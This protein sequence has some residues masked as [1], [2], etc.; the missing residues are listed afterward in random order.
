MSSAGTANPELA[1]QLRR[2]LAGATLETVPEGVLIWWGTSDL[3]SG[4]GTEPALNQLAWEG[5]YLRLQNGA[6]APGIV[7]PL[8][9]VLAGTTACRPDGQLPIAIARFSYAVPRPELAARVE[10]AA[11]EGRS[12]EDPPARI[13][14]QLHQRG[15]FFASCLLHDQWGF[16]LPAYRGRTV[17]FVVSEDFYLTNPGAAFP[18]TVAIDLGDGRGFL[19]VEFGQPIQATYAA[20]SDA[21]VAIRCTY[22]SETL[23]ASFTV[24]LS[25]QPAAPAPDES[26]P[27]E[28]DGGNT[29]T[30]FVY[31]ASGRAT[32]RRPVVI[33]EG[34]PGGHPADY[35]Y[36]ILEQQG[37]ATAL[38]AAGYD[39]VIVCLDHGTDEIQRNAQ[40]LVACIRE[41]R[42]RTDEPLIVGGVSM[43]GLVSRFA[44]AEMEARNEP[45]N[46]EVLLTIDTPH[47][48]AYTS[49][50]VQWFVHAFAPI[51]P[52]LAAQ[53]ELLNSPAN[54][55]FVLWCLRD[56]VPQTSPLRTAFLEE[57][58]GLGGY[59]K[60][61]RRLAISSGRGDG[62]STVPP[63]S[64]TLS[65][66]GQPWV[67]A[68]L[69]ALG[70]DGAETVGQGSWLLAEP[71]QLPALSFD[72]GQRPWEGAPGGQ[73]R[74][75]GQVA[76]IA[77]AVG[78]GTVTHAFDETCSVPTVSAL[79]LDQDP[80]T[81]VP[82]AGSGSS[83]FH[84]YAF[85]S[86]NQPHLTITAE[87][88]AWLLA[89]LGVT[90][91][92]GEAPAD[93]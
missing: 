20:P 44:L 50:A 93:G 53:A 75:N 89:A 36:D 76:A 49:L 85:C 65:W 10:Q 86:E 29:G 66:A 78:C 30:A 19:P 1:A 90:A 56:G 12:L 23:T 82:P 34:F 28:G 70:S 64:Q 15:A 6:L 83:P 22:G 24:P 5:E 9:T 61:P 77:A 87:V 46:A 2:L 72:S 63:G 67:S 8:D 27:L 74:Y 17:E 68:E 25:D 47:G 14:D 26:W 51:L 13:D 55:Q 60:Q 59:P 43:G 73:E 84:D 37:T 91:A 58:N 18:D 69:R 71:S 80:S 39:I 42:R 92:A 33:V 16:A 52:A 4:T 45:H 62:V 88:S 41:L 81:P 57:L 40:V 3:P 35:Q 79:D 38:R 48:G 31:H 32:V 54:Q 11:A 21:Q 7:K